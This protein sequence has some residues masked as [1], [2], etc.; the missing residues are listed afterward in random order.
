MPGITILKN[1]FYFSLVLCFH[2][3]FKLVI[4]TNR[5]GV[6]P[7]EITAYMKRVNEE[8]RKTL[9]FKKGVNI[10]H[11]LPIF[12][13]IAE[14]MRLDT[15]DLIREIE[16][17]YGYSLSK[18]IRDGI[19]SSYEYGEFVDAFENNQPFTYCGIEEDNFVGTTRYFGYIAQVFF[20]F[21]GDS[22][23]YP[24][25]LNKLLSFVKARYGYDIAPSQIQ[26]QINKG[27]TEL[28]SGDI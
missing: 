20:L 14:E 28:Y 9:D 6:K 10:F 27:I 19:K 8:L 16:G 25:F 3:C 1:F 26:P 17:H 5:K 2:L 23:E 11:H 4:E 24:H 18:D 22:K 21:G 7:M 15:E 13:R 12:F